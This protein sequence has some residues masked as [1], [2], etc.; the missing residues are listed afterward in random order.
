MDSGVTTFNMPPAPGGTKGPAGY[1]GKPSL[2]ILGVIF[3][4]L[5]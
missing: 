1:F 4:A 2:G 5:P 3:R